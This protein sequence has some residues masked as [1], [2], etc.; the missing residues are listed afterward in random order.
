CPCHYS[1]FDPEKGGQQVCGQGVA[2]LPQIELAYDSA[3]DSVRAVGVIGL[4]YGRTANI[5]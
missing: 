3:T 5:A 4:I 2:N 1:I